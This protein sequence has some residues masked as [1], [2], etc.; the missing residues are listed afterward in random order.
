M[1]DE[2][3]WDDFYVRLSSDSLTKEGEEEYLEF[4]TRHIHELNSDNPISDCE[5]CLEGELIID[6]ILDY[7][8]LHLDPLSQET[9]AR[10]VQL[11]CEKYANTSDDHFWLA[12]IA[13][14]LTESR[15]ATEEVYE[16]W[17]GNF[18]FDYSWVRSDGIDLYESFPEDLQKIAS[19]CPSVDFLNR[20][21]LAFHGHEFSDCGQVPLNECATCQDLLVRVTALRQKSE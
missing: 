20:A 13:S 1:D 6:Q 5:W 15:F 14:Q 18:E 16:T 3:Q 10:L 2:E 7:P 17:L 9:Q 11:I 12:S 21:V 8:E 19:H 4:I